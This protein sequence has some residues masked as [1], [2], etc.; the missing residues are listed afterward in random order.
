LKRH[1]D[2][3]GKAM[4]YLDPETNEKFI[5][6]IVEPALGVDRLALMLL[7]D[8][9]EEE[10]LEKDE[11]VVL[12]LH[13]AIA[14]Y[15]VAVLPLSK[16]LAQKAEEVQSILNQHF[17]TTYDET[18]SIGKRYRRQDAIGTPFCVTIDF[19]TAADQ[20]VTIRERDSMKQIRLPID[21]LIKYLRV[22]VFY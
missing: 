7:C 12:H 21:E 5:P 1:Q 22:K 13:P 10:Q 2:Y 20:S 19:D 3:S 11:R 9:Y 6:Y 14:P 16:Q 18:G 8:A 15:K 17:T 4:D